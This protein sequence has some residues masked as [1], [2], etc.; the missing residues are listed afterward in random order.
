MVIMKS[1][2]LSCNQA[3]KDWFWAEAGG[4]LCFDLGL[5]NENSLVL[6]NFIETLNLI[7]R[8]KKS[9]ASSFS[10]DTWYM[11]FFLF[12]FERKK[13][14]PILK[15]KQ[16]F[17]INPIQK[18]TARIYHA[19]KSLQSQLDRSTTIQASSKHQIRPQRMLIERIIIDFSIV[20]NLDTIDNTGR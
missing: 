10:P 12:F 20:I 16:L 19:P 2:P 8:N 9:K 7:P 15:K 13:I 3:Q 14:S 11:R 1:M 5:R 17:I 6:F 18:T 4:W